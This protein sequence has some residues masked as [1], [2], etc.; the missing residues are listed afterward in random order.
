[1]CDAE[2]GSVQVLNFSR[3]WRDSLAAVATRGESVGTFYNRQIKPDF[4]VVPAWSHDSWASRPAGRA[5]QP[6]PMGALL[7]S[8]GDETASGVSRSPARTTGRPC[9]SPPPTSNRDT[10]MTSNADRPV[11]EPTG[12]IDYSD[13]SNRIGLQLD[14][15]HRCITLAA[16]WDGRHGTE[17]RFE[18]PLGVLCDRLGITPEMVR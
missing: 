6:T 1:M 18:L 15:L 14:P 5:C 16:R 4:T 2:Q 12:V 7:V 3:R 11:T 9:R 13:G 10:S 17:I 8:T